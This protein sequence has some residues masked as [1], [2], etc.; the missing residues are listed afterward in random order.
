M[1]GMR[2]SCMIMKWVWLPNRVVILGC[3]TQIPF[4]SAMALLLSYGGVLLVLPC[5]SFH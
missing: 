5:L 3:G 1:A 2:A 4:H